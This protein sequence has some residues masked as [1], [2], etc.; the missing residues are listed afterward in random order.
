MRR[1]LLD[2]VEEMAVEGFDRQNKFEDDV[3][4]RKTKVKVD[5]FFD[6][7]KVDKYQ[8]VLFKTWRRRLERS[9]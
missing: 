2:K 5:G 6:C 7:I 4:D 9:R 3:Y 1:M 8:N